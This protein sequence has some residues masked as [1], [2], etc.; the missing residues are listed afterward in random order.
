[1]LESLAQKN[2]KSMTGEDNI[3]ESAPDT[4]FR[5]SLRPLG[6]ASQANVKS[7]RVEGTEADQGKAT[8]GIENPPSFYEADMEKWMNT[9]FSGTIKER[10][11]AKKR[12]QNSGCYI[13]LGTANP[14]S[15]ITLKRKASRG[16]LPTFTTV[17]FQA[18]G[19][20][21]QI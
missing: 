5:N 1:M 19:N 8:S 9:K 18:V 2:N 4:D 21:N 15:K 12:I 14:N 10:D 20:T 17:D 7:H 6:S 3:H 11:L 16:S 13:P